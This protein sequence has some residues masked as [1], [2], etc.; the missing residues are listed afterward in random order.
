MKKNL[1]SYLALLLS[2]VMLL[3]AFAAC[4]VPE[5]TEGTTDVIS[6]ESESASE[7]EKDT[8]KATES[9]TTSSPEGKTEDVTEDETEDETETRV[10]ASIENVEHGDIIENAVSLANGVN[11][12]FKDGKRTEFLGENQ[13]MKFEYPLAGYTDQQVTYLQNTQGKNYIENTFDVFVKMKNGNTFYAS[14]SSVATTANLFRLG[15]YY[16]DIRLEEQDF[17]NGVYNIKDELPITLEKLAGVNQVK[18]APNLKDDGSAEG[19]N[20]EIKRITDPYIVFTN[21]EYPAAEYQ[22]LKL[23]I[24]SNSPKVRSVQVYV[25][26]NSKNF[27]QAKGQTVQPSDGYNT[28]YIPIGESNGYDGTITG[29]RLDFD[30][31]VCAIGDS[32]DIAEVSVVKGNDGGAL[33]TL[34][35]ARDFLVYS[36]KM[37][38]YVQVAS[39]NQPTEN[40]DTIGLETRIDA[41]TVAKLV[42]KDAAGLHYSLDEVDWNTAEYVG[43]DI[44]EAGI[45]GYILP[46]DNSSES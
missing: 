3:G 33:R 9:N 6:G 44:K 25:R 2:L 10:P 18:V 21:V 11:A 43:F 28:F 17:F 34:S 38:H 31:S 14:K 29:L 24:K 12:Y 39:K 23:V 37:H 19:I 42:V 13:Q 16:Y 40:I 35:I 26:T 30:D 45:F 4:N 5:D 15:Y 36:N 46:A 8:E 20:V 41:D 1:L 32:F 27:Y 7:S 22:Y